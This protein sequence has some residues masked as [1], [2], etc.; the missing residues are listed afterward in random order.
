V[1]CSPSHDALCTNC[2]EGLQYAAN[3]VNGVECRNCTDLICVDNG[4]FAEGC[5]PVDDSKCASCTLGPANSFYDSPGSKAMNNCSWQ[6]NAGFQKSPS[7]CLA[8]LAGTF[9]QRGNSACTSCPAGTYSA[10]LAAT[11]SSVCNLCGAGKYSSQAGA[12]SQTTCQNCL[13]GFYQGQRGKSSCEPCQKNEYG[14]SS[15]A[16]SRSECNGCP[17]DYTTT[18]GSTGQAF[19][20]ACICNEEY[21]RIQNITFQCQ[22]CPPGL[23]C[24]GYS[25]VVPIINGS[26]WKW[27]KLNSNDYYRL[28]YCPENHQYPDLN[29]NITTDN[30]D[31]ILLNQVCTPCGAGQECLQPPCEY[32]SDCKPGYHKACAGPTPCT[33]CS[34]NTYQ[35][36]TGS[37]VCEQCDPGTSTHEKTGSVFKEEC[38]CDSTTYNL[39]QGCMD[40]PAGLKCFGNATYM[41]KTLEQ[42][43]SKWTAENVTDANAKKLLLN[44][45]F[46]PHGYFIGGTISTPGQLQCNA[47]AA[48]FECNSPPCNGACTKCRAGFYKASTIS[49]PTEV[50][51]SFYDSVSETYVTN[52]IKEPCSACPED[53]YRDREGGTEVGSC[54]KCPIRSNTRGMNGSTSVS[55]CECSVFYYR[56]GVST[57]SGLTCTD[58]PQGAVCGSDRSCALG[59]LSINSMKVGDVQNQLKC[60]NPADTVVGT[61]KRGVSGEYSLFACPPGYTMQVSNFTNAFSSCILC[62]EGTY[63]LEE[64]T[65]TETTCKPCPSGAECPGGNI[66]NPK[67]GFWKAPGT[68]RESMTQVFVYQCPPGFCGEKN[69]CKNNRTGPV[70]SS[71]LRLTLMPALLMEFFIFQVCGLCPGGWALTSSGC[72]PCPGENVLAPSRNAAIAI[73]VL[74]CVALWY[75]F[76]WRPMI[77]D[78]NE[79]NQMDI[80]EAADQVDAAKSRF[81]SVKDSLQLLADGSQVL[82]PYLKLYISFFQVLA[83]FVSFPV[84]W[85]SLLLDIMSWIK[86]TLFLDIAALPGLSCLWLGVSFQSR[87]ISYTLGSLAVIFLL[88]V[89]V[90]VHKAIVRYISQSSEQRSEG[91]ISAA[92]KNIMFWVFLIYPIVSLSTMQAFNCQ[93]FGLGLLAADFNEPCPSPAHFLRIWSYI[94]IAVYPV[95]IPLFCYFSMLKMGVHLVARDIQFSLLLKSLVMKYASLSLISTSS[96]EIKPHDKEIIKLLADCAEDIKITKTQAVDIL[97]KFAVLELEATR[98]KKSFRT[99]ISSEQGADESM[100][101]AMWSSCVPVPPNLKETP[102]RIRAQIQK[103]S[104]ENPGILYILLLQLA[105]RLVEKKIIAIPSISWAEYAESSKS[106]SL[107]P[108]QSKESNSTDTPNILS[109]DDLRSVYAIHPDLN[110]DEEWGRWI[111]SQSSVG[112]MLKTI[113]ETWK[114]FNQRKQMGMKAVDRIGFVFAAYKVDFWYWE[115]LEMLRK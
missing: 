101:S 5:S 110:D 46:C 3:I 28:K 79:Q 107:Q 6:C 102:D 55:N 92:W 64:V 62:S 25:T 32:C 68:R 95:G 100:N 39:G 53:T 2:L 51:G 86:G 7:A 80:V 37:L 109:V 88:M 4:T 57:T 72:L 112:N 49:H 27:V 61:W 90:L 105:Q 54:T 108:A 106:S 17:S 87:L 98:K 48:G 63:L 33:P 83:S 60:T 103:E 94:F 40:C 21:Y 43:E 13:I 10:N 81:N 52:W 70:D 15:G 71:S 23:K 20:T 30:V 114:S 96:I 22:K 31:L 45:K 75:Y 89:P 34:I 115:M 82:S 97:V 14:V 36:G 11:S 1:N 99:K 113:P 73:S 50:P 69:N 29:I 93:P 111:K 66:V 44:L 67:S 77:F 85:P 35:P 47:C 84:V 12:T 26:I 16:S 18:R 8:C 76:S 24:T 78:P 58:C 41:P 104:N 65:S 59:L 19:Q 56:G 91:V 9:S 38:T 42:G 74:C